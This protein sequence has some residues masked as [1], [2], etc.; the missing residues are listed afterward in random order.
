M[1]FLF[2]FLLLFS[3][4]LAFGQGMMIPQTTTINTPY[5]NVKSTSYSYSHMNYGNGSSS[6]SM[7]Y[8][9]EI[10]LPA[11]STLKTKAKIDFSE[12]THSMQVK[13]NQ[14]KKTLSPSDT[15]EI[16]RITADGKIVKGISADS[17][18]LFRT[19]E[20]KINVYSFL[21][22]DHYTYAIAIQD[23]ENGPIIPITRKNLEAIVGNTAD[24]RVLKL[25]E[26]KKLV[27]AI[28]L[29]NQGN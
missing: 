29:Y 4:G 16:Y 3:A 20:S 13:T 10:V 18:W 21:P 6:K 7:K 24:P 15:K 22:Q 19:V 8:N 27:P 11:D 5:G 9:F 12:K 14:G 17:C 2:V 28:Q 26:R 25:I 23:G 1:K